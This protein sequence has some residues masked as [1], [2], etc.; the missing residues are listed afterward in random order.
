[1]SL[2][3]CDNFPVFI[4]LE[5]RKREPVRQALVTVLVALGGWAIAAQDKYRSPLIDGVDRRLWIVSP[6]RS[7]VCYGV[8]GG[9]QNR[10]PIFISTVALLEVEAFGASPRLI[11]GQGREA[12]RRAGVL[13]PPH[14]QPA[15]PQ[16]PGNYLL[17]V[18]AMTPQR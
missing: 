7:A 3:D 13:F 17:L 8:L 10:A 14:A 15:D 18:A 16:K 2:T 6:F 1:L 5:I 9:R 11:D 12:G 4:S